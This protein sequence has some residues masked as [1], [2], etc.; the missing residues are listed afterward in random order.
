MLNEPH[1]GYIDIPSLHNWDYNT[2]LHLSYI[3]ACFLVICYRRS[4]K[5]LPCLASAFNSF[6]LG[7]G[8]PTPVAHWIRS[9]PVPTK[10]DKHVLL[11]QEKLSAWREDGPTAGKC[12]WEMHGVWT[13]DEKHKT[14]IVLREHYFNNHPE[15]GQKVCHSLQLQKML[16]SD[17]I[18]R[19]VYQFL[20]SFL[21]E[22][23]R[24]GEG[25]VT[26]T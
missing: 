5:L 6:T 25:S 18:D 1:R 8:Y 20:L 9:F 4:L 15:T 19:L 7:A 11:N 14:A 22:V 26:A 3:R 2:D 21:A 12:L 13:Y 10:M 24:S 23:G 16:T 17:L